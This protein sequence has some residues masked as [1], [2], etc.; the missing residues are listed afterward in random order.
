MKAN[1]WNKV[2]LK[3][4]DNCNNTKIGFNIPLNRIYNGVVFYVDDIQIQRA[5]GT[6]VENIGDYEEESNELFATLSPIQRIIMLCSF[7]VLVIAIII[8]ILVFI[9]KTRKNYR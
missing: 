9:K 5:D 8:G 1:S 2:Q 6:L 3:V 7:G 4:P